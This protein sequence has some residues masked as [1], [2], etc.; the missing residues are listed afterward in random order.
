MMPSI[1]VAANTCTFAYVC[2]LFTLVR[3]SDPSWVL[4]THARNMT[5]RRTSQRSDVC[6]QTVV[7]QSISCETSADFFAGALPL[8]PA[9]IITRV[10]MFGVLV[11]FISS[12]LP[13][14]Y[15]ASSHGGTMVLSS[16]T[17][18]LLV[19]SLISHSPSVVAS[20]FFWAHLPSAFASVP[21]PPHEFL[22]TVDSMVCQPSCN[23]EWWSEIC[24]VSVTHGRKTTQPKMF[25]CNK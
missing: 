24:A 13:D 17:S 3:T 8:P 5:N 19:L 10:S 18:L 16:L 15:N 1:F 25:E 22:P 4:N 23:R 9:Y 21:A 20:Q 2:I 12:Y 7:W 14:V 11:P 6:I